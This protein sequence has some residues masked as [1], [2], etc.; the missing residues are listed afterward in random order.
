MHCGANSHHDGI[1]IPTSIP[2][3]KTHWSVS[4]CV[5]IRLESK[6]RGV[7]SQ[8]GVFHRKCIREENHDFL[9]FQALLAQE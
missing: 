1:R 9:S 5:I 8:K 4:Q 3:N 2:K 6:L 7:A